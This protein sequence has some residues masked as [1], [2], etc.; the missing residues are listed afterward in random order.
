M[1]YD[2]IVLYDSSTGNTKKLATE[3]FTSL[4]GRD[5]DLLP[6][7]EYRPDHTA[8]IYFIG[9][10]TNRGSCSVEM[11]DF[12]STL[13][14]KKIALFGT[15]GMGDSPIYYNDI[16]RRVSVWLPDDNEFLG[17]FMCLGK[18]P[19]KIR[20]YYEDSYAEAENKGQVA[21][22]LHYY[23]EAMIHPNHTDFDNAA[24][25]ARGIIEKRKTLPSERDA[26]WNL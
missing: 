3:I 23:D 2:Y 18:M 5:K 16:I 10:R 13:H 14:E 24:D 20:K 1:D 6:I 17:S 15:C 19:I 7:N 11:M 8:D 12:L 22:L 21:R 9:F 26:S 25:F 4:P